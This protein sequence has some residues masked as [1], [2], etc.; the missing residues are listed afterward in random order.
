MSFRL[1]PKIKESLTQRRKGATKSDLRC[2]VASLRETSS[3]VWVEGCALAPWVFAKMRIAGYP[4]K[5]GH[6]QGLPVRPELVEGLTT[7][8]LTCPALSWC[9]QNRSFLCISKL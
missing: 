5:A 4:L 8:G 1:R 7:N 3:A 6:D 2:A 9:P